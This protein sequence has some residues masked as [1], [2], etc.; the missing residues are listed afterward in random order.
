VAPS[1]G[2]NEFFLSKLKCRRVAED[3][4]RVGIVDRLK[5]F[6]AAQERP[7]SSGGQ[8]FPPPATRSLLFK[9]NILATSKTT[10]PANRN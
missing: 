10:K 5:K 1:S 7:Q 2:A 9:C 8:M 3:E 6:A 4:L